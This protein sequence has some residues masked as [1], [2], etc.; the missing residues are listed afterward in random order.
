MRPASGLV[1]LIAGFAV[2]LLLLAGIAAVAIAHMRGLSAELS[3]IVV[4]RNE[5]AAMASALLGLHQARYQSLN[6]ATH[7]A[8]PFE[9]DVELQHY[10]Q[11]AQEYIASRE[12]F[13]ET[14]LDGL[15]FEMWTQIRG[16]VAEV[17]RHSLQVLA[18][19]AEDRL[20]RARAELMPIIAAHQANSMNLWTQMVELQRQYN[21]QAVEEADTAR[22]RAERLTLA[23]SGLAIVVGLAVTGLA[24]HT[25]NRLSRALLEE[26]ELAQITLHSMG[27]AVLRIDAQGRICYRN[28]AAEALL[29]S[30][31][32]GP[33][34]PEAEAL[35]HLHDP[36]H[37]GN[38]LPA[39]LREAHLG[40]EVNLPPGT[41]LRSTDGREHRVAGKLSPLHD[42]GDRQGGSVLVMR[43]IGP[44][45]GVY[46][47]A[48]KA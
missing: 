23:M 33:D 44:S 7:L 21:H 5:K 29:G 27:D 40:H 32:Q 8:D 35:L 10:G 43:K 22:R 42:S 39:L 41:R 17:E 19:L 48:G 4:E 45:D 6:L 30:A 34:E 12:R 13:L 31:A 20:D 26:K 47:E 38:R 1:P 14:P 16:Q 24:I 36:G 11:L 2:M 9:R 3:A 15:E 28:V 46:P 18:L 25:Y 37:E